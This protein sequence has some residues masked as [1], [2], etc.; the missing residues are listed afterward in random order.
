[1][2][3]FTKIIIFIIF[4]F[5]INVVF[6]FASENYRFFL[7]KLKNGEEIVYVNEKNISDE[8][9]E[10]EK[11][12]EELKWAWIVEVKKEYKI[13]I[14]EDKEKKQKIVLWKDYKDIISLFDEYDLWKIEIIWNIFDITDE[15]P[16]DFLEYY[17]KDL[18]LYLFTS[19]TYEDIKNIFKVISYDSSFEIN[20]VNNFLWK[21]FYINLDDKINDN[22]VRIVI[23]YKS[24]VFWLKINKDKYNDVKEL[25]NNIEIL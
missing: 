16:D 14:E 13:D 24:I 3:Y 15:Y 21:S 12:E 9:I 17:S 11:I 25:L 1:M 8:I 20:E 23:W 5:L 7:K 2:K 6:Y 18:V 4:I 22:F 10:D 19:K